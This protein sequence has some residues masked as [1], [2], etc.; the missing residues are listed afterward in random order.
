MQA[1]VPPHPTG[2]LPGE[3]RIP[4]VRGLPALQPCW[5]RRR[6]RRPLGA[7]VQGGGP[8]QVVCPQGPVCLRAQ[9]GQL[10]QLHS[11]QSAW[12]K[13][14]GW[15]RRTRWAVWGPVRLPL[16]HQPL[17]LAS[18]P[19]PGWARHLGPAQAPLGD[20]AHVQKWR[21]S[22]TSRRPRVSAEGLL[23]SG[24][25]PPRPSWLSGA[26]AV[27]AVPLHQPPLRCSC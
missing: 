16:G 22:R 8:A 11:S 3:L 25:P 12:D 20:H 26:P 17:S 13:S 6:D 9:R 2:F 10:C 21:P 27:G 15:G 23:G 24:T 4:V 18:G 1:G 14:W 7:H 5:V 19:I